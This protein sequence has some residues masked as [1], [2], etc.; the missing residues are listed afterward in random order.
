M[1]TTPLGVVIADDLYELLAR[2]VGTAYSI[3]ILRTPPDGRFLTIVPNRGSEYAPLPVTLSQIRQQ[4][5]PGSYFVEVVE[6]AHLPGIF[7]DP[8]EQLYQSCGYVTVTV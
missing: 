4:F 2:F 8:G 5:G 6:P 3:R 1:R 7:Q